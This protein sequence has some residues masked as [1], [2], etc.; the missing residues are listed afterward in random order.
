MKRKPRPRKD[1]DA[2]RIK[3]IRNRWDKAG[4]HPWRAYKG[5][6]GWDVLEP[7]SAWDCDVLIARNLDGDTAYLL[8]CVPDDI[9]FLLML[10][11]RLK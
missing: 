2:D 11:E 7:R 8:A 4:V 9:Q 3:A 1:T 6:Y 5:M 10:A